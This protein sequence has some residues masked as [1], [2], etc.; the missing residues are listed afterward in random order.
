MCARQPV[1]TGDGGSGRCEVRRQ[2]RCELVGH[3]LEEERRGRAE[4]LAE[5]QEALRAC[6]ERLEEE[7][8]Q[9]KRAYEGG[10][11]AKVARLEQV[12]LGS[13]ERIE[14]FRQNEL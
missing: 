5:A 2:A 4:D 1:V 7:A 9:W 8:E 3:Q 13:R 11:N 10:D 12:G 6:R 14:Y